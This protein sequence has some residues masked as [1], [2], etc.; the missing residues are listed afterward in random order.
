MKFSNVFASVAAGLAILQSNFVE[1]AYLS[2]GKNN[3][4]YWGQGAN[5]ESLATYCNKGDIDIVILSFLKN[6]NNKKASFN[7][8]NA[9]GGDSCDQIAKDIVTCQNKGVKVLLSLGGDSRTGTYGVKNDNQGRSAAKVIYNMFHPKG[10]GKVKPFGDAEIDG[11]DFDIENEKQEGL[12]ALVVELRRLWT[13]KKLIVS[14]APQCPYPDK[15]VFK[16]LQSKDAKVDIAWVQFY[17]NPACSFNNES[18]F[19]QSWETWYKFVTQLSGNSDMKIYVGVASSTED[20]AYFVDADTTATRSQDILSQSA[21]GGFCLWD[22]SSGT[23]KVTN[24]V[25]YVTSLK[26]IL[27]GKSVT[28]RSYDG[29]HKQYTVLAP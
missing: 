4:V 11:I 24:D 16:L 26:N 25:S 9:C 10:T 13:T 3:A 21:F 17:N 8:G 23:K 7:F 2:N 28:K 19:K 22:V 1:A 14:A 15:N 18:G 12:A 27:D 29:P 6:W 5:Q 20:S